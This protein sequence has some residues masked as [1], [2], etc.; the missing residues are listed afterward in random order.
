LA[1]AE[2]SS[3]SPWLLNSR[4]L[5]NIFFLST[6][7]IWRISP[8][9]SDLSPHGSPRRK[10]ARAKIPGRS[11]LRISH[12]LW[13]QPKR[14][15]KTKETIDGIREITK[16]NIPDVNNQISSSYP[17]RSRNCAIAVALSSPRD[18]LSSAALTYLQS[19]G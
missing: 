15:I 7:T 9:H 18:H 8:I 19:L 13:T 4:M 1:K 10:Q 6:C 12:G 3:P 16:M 11:L 5:S 2:M 17:G 14:A